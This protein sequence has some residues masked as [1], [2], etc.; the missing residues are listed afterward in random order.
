MKRVFAV[1]GLL[2]ALTGLVNAVTIT[3]S[4]SSFTSVSA[5]VT[6]AARGDTV[7]VPAGSSTWSSPLVLTKGINLSGAGRDATTLTGSGVLIA[8]APDAT[9]IANEETIRVEGFTFDGNNTA[10]NFIT[11]AG[12]VAS[13]SKPFKN[14]AIGNNRFRNSGTSTSGSG[15]VSISGQA[16]GAI[17]KNIFD[18][19]NVVA[20]IMGND[21]TT[22]WSSGRFPFAYG[23]SDNLFF[24]DNVIQYS[25][26]FS[27]QDPGWTE[28]GQGARWCC[29]Y[30]TWNMAN[31]NQQ[32]LWDIHGFQNWGS[33]GQTGT[34]ISEYYGNTIINTSGYRWINH[35]GSWGLFFISGSGAMSIEINQYQA[36]DTGGSGCTIAVPGASGVYITEVNNS[37]VFNN[38]KGGSVV[39]MGEGSIGNGCGVAENGGYW[40][41]NPAF[42]GSNG[43]GRGTTPPTGNC[44][45]GAAYWV[46]STPTPTTNSAVIQSGTLYKCLTSNVWTLYY[47]PYT[48]PHPLQS[49]G[50]GSSGG[51]VPPPT[52]LRVVAN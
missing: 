9:A 6:A 36:G 32:E 27:G 45:V 39:N 21:D 29:R 13:S 35:R 25:S 44:S 51:P 22:E 49:G 15:A 24:E 16:R 11:V 14:L 30:N 38:T 43:I 48:Y 19:V 42:V 26:A 8:I 46:A 41:F 18:R 33:A 4:S 23:N 7:L 28:T 37:Y 2:M 47:K 1:S 40:N 12:A 52:S 50:S 10:L 5:A 31:A 17:F 20:K 34:M 3:A